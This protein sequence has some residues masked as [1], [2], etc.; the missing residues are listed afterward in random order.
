MTHEV[1]LGFCTAYTVPSIRPKPSVSALPKVAAHIPVGLN[2]SVAEA[3]SAASASALPG[4]AASSV[5]AST[6]GTPLPPG[7][8]DDEELHATATAPRA[9]VERTKRAISSYLMG[10]RRR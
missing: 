2:A 1:S 8:G 10:L 4:K 5:P 6:T 7:S 9:T 3:A